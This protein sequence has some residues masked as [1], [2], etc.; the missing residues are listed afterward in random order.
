MYIYMHIHIHISCISI[1][2][3]KELTGPILLIFLMGGQLSSNAWQVTT[4]GAHHW[5]VSGPVKPNLSRQLWRGEHG[6]PRGLPQFTW[7][8]LVM[9]LNPSTFH[10]L[11]RLLW[12]TLS[13]ASEVP[14]PE[15]KMRAFPASDSLLYSGTLRETTS[16]LVPKVHSNPPPEIPMFKKLS[17]LPVPGTLYV[18]LK[19]GM[20]K[21]TTHHLGGMAPVDIKRI[22]PSNFNNQPLGKQLILRE[23]VWGTFFM[24]FPVFLSLYV[25]KL[26]CLINSCFWFP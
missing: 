16:I 9:N 8:S 19:P 5:S 17:D 21:L 1:H 11:A 7:K 24:H 13:I 14:A 4:S 23:Y 12:P 18:W 25:S 3:Q 15:L 6:N 20:P 22:F 10:V 26:Y 2:Q